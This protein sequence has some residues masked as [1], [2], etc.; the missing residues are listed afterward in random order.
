MELTTADLQHFAT[1]P[2]LYWLARDRPNPY[3]TWYDHF[4]SCMRR[5]FTGYALQVQAGETPRIR[6]LTKRWGDLYY[7]KMTKQDIIGR[8]THGA[9]YHDPDRALFFMGTVAIHNRHKDWAKLAKQAV[10]VGQEWLLPSGGHVLKGRYDLITQEDGQVV[11]WDLR[12]HTTPERRSART[13]WTVTA[14]ATAFARD[15]GRPPDA[16]RVYEAVLGDV[17]NTKRTPGD[18]ELLRSCVAQVGDAISAH[19]D[20]PAFAY[21]CGPCPFYRNCFQL[22]L[23]QVK[24]T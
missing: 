24:G 16:I 10:V 12:F 20:Y 23:S 11:L 3:M 21:Q 19:V 17:V 18:Q 22:Y 13:D 4:D 1:C 7:P 5:L 2:R 6:W 8:V 15:F 14:A 9:R